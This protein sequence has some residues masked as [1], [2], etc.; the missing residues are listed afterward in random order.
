[1][2]H[3]IQVDRDDDVT[4]IKAKI[5]NVRGRTV[6]LVVP[7]DNRELKS[8][9]VTRVLSTAA[10]DAGINLAIISRDAVVRRLARE[11]GIPQFGSIGEYRHYIEHGPGFVA[12]VQRGFGI[13]SRGT[14]TAIALA[15]VVVFFVI[16]GAA[17]YIF[18]PSATVVLSPASEVLTGEV[19]VIADPSA[20]GPDAEKMRVPARV[21]IQTAE[22]SDR[23]PATGFQPNLGGRFGG[24]VT[25]TNRT[26][27]PLSVPPGSTVVATNGA[28][29]TTQ[30]EAR[31]DPGGTARVIVHANDAGANGAVGRLAITRL[32]GPL[33]NQ[34]SVLNEDATTI[35]GDQVAVSQEDR[36]RVRQA[37]I[38]RTRD[39]A[40]AK[41][42]SESAEGEV[43]IEESFEFTPLEEWW[44]QPAGAAA[45]EVTYRLF[46]RAKAMYY[47]REMVE[48]LARESWRPDIRMGF[49]ELPE[50]MTVG[51]ARA[52]E[53]TTNSARLIVPVTTV[54]VA[55]I[56]RERVEDYVRWRPPD[57]ARRD[58]RSLLSLSDDPQI[59]LS[60]A[61]A[62]RAYRVNV[63]LDLEKVYAQEP[64]VVGTSR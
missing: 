11:T 35:F 53:V 26:S 30:Q 15:S 14:S 12:G 31:L 13:V 51:E 24:R 20:R 9:L 42:R 6:A 33:Q 56:N 29:F 61:W 38:E 5:I 58:L 60:P 28:R 25:I 23:T 40:L 7:P 62:A 54:A 4:S 59:E 44:S 43:L 34:V 19:E 2:Y 36:E 22:A 32:E 52:H 18:Y 21:V 49:R 50:S 10:H 57:V 39:D 47:V 37:T 64:P 3:V 45:S 63:F 8:P 55:E 41:L 1:M 16:L 17:F 27:Q 46:A 48:S